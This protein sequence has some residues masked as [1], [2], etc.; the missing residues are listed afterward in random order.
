MLNP[1]R[2]TPHART[3]C[4]QEPTP[5]FRLKTNSTL[6]SST[7]LPDCATRRFAT[8]YDVSAR[9]VTSHGKKRSK[10]RKSACFRA[11]RI[12]LLLTP[13]SRLTRRMRRLRTLHR[14]P[15]CRAI[16][17]LSRRQAQLATPKTHVFISTLQFHALYRATGDPP[18]YTARARC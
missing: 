3:T 4:G 11:P 18:I 6:L 13:P 5:S 17:A 1:S 7:S 9:T 8:T 2:F 12:G 14:A 10:W 15:R 16:I